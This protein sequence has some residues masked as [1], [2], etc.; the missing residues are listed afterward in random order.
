MAAID[1]SARASA[2]AAFMMVAGSNSEDRVMSRARSLIRP[3]CSA[4]TSGLAA[5]SLLVAVAKSSTSLWN[6]YNPKP[7]TPVVTAPPTDPMATRS[8]FASPCMRADSTAI[9]VPPA[10]LRAAAPIPRSAAAAC[11]AGPVTSSIRRTISDDVNVAIQKPQALAIR[12]A[13]S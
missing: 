11:L 13:S 4:V 12:T 1:T 5:A 6:L 3:I 9:P 2:L 10:A 8:F 7:V